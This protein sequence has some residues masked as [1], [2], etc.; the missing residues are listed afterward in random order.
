MAGMGISQGATF[1]VMLMASRLLGSTAFGEYGIIQST[2]R[3]IGLLAGVGL[4]LTTKKYVSE[5]RDKDTARSGRIIGMTI[6]VSW[7]SASSITIGLFLLAPILAVQTMKAPHLALELRISA[8]LL[9]FNALNGTQIGALAGLEAFKKITY[10][11][12]IRGVLTIILVTVGVWLLRLAGMLAGMTAT[13]MLVWLLTGIVLRASCN[14]LGI[15]VAYRGVWMEAKLLWRFTAPGFISSLLPGFVFWVVRTVLVQHPNGYSELGIFTLADQ[16]TQ[17]LSFVP[18]S[19]NAA[20]LPILSNEYGRGDRS[21]FRKAALNSI[22]LPVGVSGLFAIAIAIASPWVE[23]YY[24]DS[25]AGISGVL[26]LVCLVAVMKVLGGSLGSLL[27]SIGQMWWGVLL[28]VLWGGTLI[29]GTLLLT[30]RGA[31]GLAWAYLIAYSLH[32]MW[33]SLLLV[34]KTQSLKA[35]GRTGFTGLS[36]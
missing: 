36:R 28:N 22:L 5:Y 1:A 2:T 6:T 31:P 34:K 13:A 29:V 14:R 4:G 17:L 25:F 26:R 35:H 19:L 11:Y 7:V 27:A 10:I 8:L 9:L 20:G 23:G 3:M 32:S 16:W 18:R 12:V 15:E 33:G 21:R 30:E 24:G